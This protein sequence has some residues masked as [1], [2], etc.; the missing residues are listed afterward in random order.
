MR[1]PPAAAK[2]K[3]PACGA[4][5]PLDLPAPDRGKPVLSYYLGIRQLENRPLSKS[6][7]ANSFGNRPAPHEVTN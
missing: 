5:G 4:L 3:A 6:N 1:Q 2:K 7:P